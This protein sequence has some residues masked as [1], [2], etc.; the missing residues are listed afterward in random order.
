MRGHLGAIE[1]GLVVDLRDKVE[2]LRRH[3][4][5][6]AG[7]QDARIGDEHVQGAEVQDGLLHQVLQAVHVGHVG[8]DE[9]G[10]VVPGDFVEG[11]GR[12]GARGLV[13]VG[14]DDV[15]ALG[16][17]FPGDALAEALGRARDDDGLAFHPAGGSAG[18]HLAAVVLHF[19]VVDEIDP[20]GLHRM[21]PAEGSGIERHL[22]RVQEHLGDNAGVL[23]VVAHGHE[24]DSFDQQHLRG[25]SPA[26][27][28][29]LDLL[30]GLPDRIL[31][32]QDDILAL[33]ID[34][35]VRG[36]G[37]ED[38]RRILQETVHEGVPGDLQGL[39]TATAAGQ[40]LADGRQDLGHFGGHLL[41][42]PVRSGLYT[43]FQAVHDAGIDP[44][45]LL[46]RVGTHENAMVLQ[47]DDLRLAAAGGLPGL[48]AVIDLLEKGIAGVRV[49]DIEGVREEFGAG[50]RRLHGT[51]QAIHQRRV[52]VHHIREA[53]AVVQGG[54]HGGTAA[55][56]QAGG[57]QVFLDLGLALGDVSAVRLL[58]HRIQL[59][60]VQDGKTVLADG[61][62]GM[63]AGLH[64]EMVF[65]LVGGISTASD[66]VASVAS[67]LPGDGDEILNRSHRSM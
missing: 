49:L 1:I 22:H 20:G 65:I 47:E 44:V 24:A 11:S 13:E 29:S 2:V 28:V 17:E 66:D 60:A 56:G 23:G 36:K 41:A 46:G 52:Q 16:Q 58:P 45:D 7:A 34:D 3:R 6:A 64:P 53:H 43:G 51:H 5:Q 42:H 50:F 19:P 12:R 61:G 25:M 18:R 40:D 8:L 35:D 9:D 55:F 15:R 32:F 38:G 4:L 39:E 30:L 67:V 21:F 14:H 59:A 26:G 57:G 31:G 33:A 54:L 10:P 62:E 27:D 37:M 48:D 63:A